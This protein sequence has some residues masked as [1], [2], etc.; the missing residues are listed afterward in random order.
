[1]NKIICERR[2]DEGIRFFQD[3]ISGTLRT[4]HACGDKL[5]LEADKITNLGGR[6]RMIEGNVRIRKLTPKECFRL[7]GFDDEDYDVLSENGVSNN[8]IYKQAGNSIVVNVLEMLLKNV[9]PYL[10][11]TTDCKETEGKIE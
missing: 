6:K 1:M 2:Y 9:E 11:T 8:Q 10:T 7:M 5:V 4:I 3:D